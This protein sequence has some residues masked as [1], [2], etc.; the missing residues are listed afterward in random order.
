MTMSED[1]STFVVYAKG[2]AGFL[3]TM[4]ERATGRAFAC[5][6]VSVTSVV[7]TNKYRRR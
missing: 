4:S 1:V 5:V 6:S 7:E 3:K 2:D